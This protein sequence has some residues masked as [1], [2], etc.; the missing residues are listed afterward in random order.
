[1][2]KI[3]YIMLPLVLLMADC[4]KEI[5]NINVNPKAPLVVPSTTVFTEAEHTLTNTITS[6]NVNLNIFRL[7]VQQW[8]ETTYT[9]ESRYDLNT[10]TIPD[11]VWNALYRDVL[12]NFEQVKAL[13]ATEGLSADN[14]K[15]NNAITDVLEVY[16]YY[17]LLTTF[18]NI[19]Y[20]QALNDN[21]LFP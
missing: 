6:A 17:Y 18:G 14:L 11:G 2:K 10:R 13:G 1:M 3:L 8:Q 4:K 15:T 12:K 16:T 9:D 19:P 21:V 5:T 20:T 7:I